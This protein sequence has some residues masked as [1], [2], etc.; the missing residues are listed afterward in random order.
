MN[1]SKTTIKDFIDYIITFDNVDD[2]LDTLEFQSSKCF[3]FE[4]IFDVIIKFGFCDVFTNNAYNHYIF[5]SNT[6]V[7]DEKFKLLKKLSKYLDEKVYSNEFICGY[8]ITL[9]RKTD[10]T[11]IFVKSAYPLSYKDIN[12]Q[13]TIK[14]Y[15]IDELVS[16]IKNN[17]RFYKKYDIYLLVIDKKKVVNLV[18]TLKKPSINVS[19]YMVESNILDKNDLNRYFLNFKKSIIK[20]KN[21]KWQNLYFNKKELLDLIF[22]QKM[23]IKKSSIL[24]EEGNKEF[25]WGLKNIDD[26]LKLVGSIILDQIHVKGKINV[27]IVIPPVRQT[28]EQYTELFNKYENFDIYKIHYIENYE[29]TNDIEFDENNIFIISEELLQKYTMKK[30]IMKIKDLKLDIIFFDENHFNETTI[31]TKNILKSYTSRFTIIIYLTSP[32]NKLFRSPELLEELHI[33]SECQIN[34]DI[35]DDQICKSILVDNTYVDKL[36]EKHSWEYITKTITHYTNLGMSI[37]DIFK[38]YE[39]L[40]N[41]HLITNLF[42]K[43]RYDDIRKKINTKN[44]KKFCYN[45]LFSLNKKK[46]K[47]NFED[48]VKLFIRYMSGSFKERDGE[49]T[50]LTRINYIRSE[51]DS[52]NPLTQIW[53]LPSENINEISECLK[54]LMSKDMVLK[55]YDILCVD[56]YNNDEL[57]NIDNMI[58]ETEKNGKFGLIILAENTLSLD[59]KLNSCD[60]IFLLNNSLS[61]DDVLQQMYRCMTKDD[62]KNVGFVVD[63]NAN[64]VL[65]TCMNYTNYTINENN[66]NID[67]KIRHL[68]KNNIINIDVDMTFHKKNGID[69]IVNKLMEV[70]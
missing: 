23:I 9:K 28:P 11:Y 61:T 32:F 15:G 29:M 21:K 54:T 44:N 34:W 42:D 18:K 56:D 41:L 20:N 48:E 40:P 1:F 57:I 51:S 64:R 65:N 66:K 3:I 36:I 2:I 7:D 26:K 39:K 55:S 17:Y 47:F 43:D 24:M 70:K 27:L 60:I 22:H 67:E 62:D 13:K 52:R 31:F 25:L 10:D 12:K 4:R 59:I 16:K 19:K 45:T 68:I 35:E 5:N 69:D 49:K 63:L 33:L 37:N 58:I 46:T 30:T 8:N 53:F 6:N 14:H 50:I 38:C